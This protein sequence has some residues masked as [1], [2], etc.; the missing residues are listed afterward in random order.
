MTMQDTAPDSVEREAVAREY[1][2]KLLERHNDVD[3]ENDIRSAFRDFLVR[4]EIAGS[5]SEIVTETR[6]APDSRHK[7]DLYLGNTYVEFKDRHNSRPFFPVC[8][9]RVQ[10]LDTADRA[11]IMAQGAAGQ[12]LPYSKLIGPRKTRNPRML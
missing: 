10:P 2:G 1:L 3:S 11:E 8:T 9:E 7:V 12:Q 6:P 5:E 4:T